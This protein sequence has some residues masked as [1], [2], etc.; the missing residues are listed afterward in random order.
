MP[1]DDTFEIDDMLAKEFNLT[2]SDEGEEEFTEDDTELVEEEKESEEEEEEE[3]AEPE[4]SDPAEENEEEQEQEE[5]E[6][7]EKPT[8]EEQKEYN[9]AQFR[10]ENAK[11]KQERQQLEAVAKANGYEDVDAFIKDLNVASDTK[12]AQAQNLDPTL[13]REL[14]EVKR[15]NQEL[16]QQISTRDF[17]ARVGNLRS[18]MDKVIDELGLGTKEEGTEIIMDRLAKSG[19]EVDEIISLSNPELLIRGALIDKIQETAKQKQISKIEKLDKVSGSKHTGVA[20][21]AT[22]DLDKLVQQEMKEYAEE[23]YLN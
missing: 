20:Q 15:K 12:M 7:D 22:I 1:N 18:V 21:K 6:V 23:N 16:E 8:K 19:Y 4:E 14:M 5:Q 17:E 9:F 11:L 2:D 13:Y 10:T 3:V